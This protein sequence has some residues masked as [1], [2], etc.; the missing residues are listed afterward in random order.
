MILSAMTDE[1]IVDED[2]EPI[3]TSITAALAELSELSSQELRE[4]GRMAYEMLYGDP[5]PNIIRK[6]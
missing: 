5:L 4:R 1:E 3:P 6:R 2:G